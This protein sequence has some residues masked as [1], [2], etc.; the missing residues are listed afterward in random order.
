[1]HC[2]KAESGLAGKRQK[3]NNAENGETPRKHA[4]DYTARTNRIKSARAR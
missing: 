1:V 2:I 3:R 4:A